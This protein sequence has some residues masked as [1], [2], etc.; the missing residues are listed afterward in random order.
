MPVG[1][2]PLQLT[3][4]IIKPSVYAS[5]PQVQGGPALLPRLAELT[6]TSEIMK[7]IKSTGL[8]VRLR[9]RWRWAGR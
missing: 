7:T 6:E 3:L 1:A 5:Q 4:G 2:G 9:A 8:E